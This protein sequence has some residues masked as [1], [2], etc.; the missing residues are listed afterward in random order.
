MV[1]VKALENQLHQARR[2][3]IDAQAAIG[4]VEEMLGE[5]RQPIRNVPLPGLARPAFE[6]PALSLVSRAA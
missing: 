5:M 6:A 3:R 4:D 1:D 2:A